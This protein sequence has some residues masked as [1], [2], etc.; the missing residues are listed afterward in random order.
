[1]KIRFLFPLVLACI[2]FVPLATALPPDPRLDTEPM[3]ATGSRGED[4]DVIPGEGA[5]GEWKGALDVGVMQLRL[6]L[7]VTQLDDGAL[8]GTL[9]SLDQGAMGIPLDT[10]ESGD[11]VLR[12]HIKSIGAFYRGEINEDGSAI[13]GTWTQLGREHPLTFNRTKTAFTLKR[14]QEP[15]PPFPYTSEEVR[16]RN[17]ADA[18]TLAGTLLVPEGEGPF[19]AVLM[20]TGSGPQDRDE[21]L[22]GHKPFLVIADYLARRGIAS[23]RY[24][25]RGFGESG[26]N[27]M[28]ST[29]TDFAEDASAGIAY[30]KS[31]PEIR[32]S[33]IGI[34]GHSE[35]GL[36]GAMVAS[37]RDDVAFLVLLAAPGESFAKLL[38]RQTRDILRLKGVEEDLINRHVAH[39]ESAIA[40]IRD[41]SLPRAE[42]KEK[43]GKLAKDERASYTEEEAKAL[44][45][46][47]AAIERN[48]TISTTP[49]FRSLAR[50][51]PADYLGEID[52]P[53]LALFGGKDVQVAAEVNAAVMRSLLEQADN[54]DFEV[55]IL[56]G[57]NHLF[58]HA[59]TGA[60]REY[61]K[62]EETFAPEALERMGDWIAERFVR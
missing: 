14:P 44:G 54:P 3:N 16:F 48:I 17:E 55:A 30:L 39:L 40:L 58:Q 62:I 19:P 9:D 5:V 42:L 45:F 33:A 2:A 22:M 38:V 21:L 28:A 43:L 51:D 41:A 53:T 8:A 57:L 11:G 26:G 56:P 60:I 34:V 24:D 32:Q 61:G 23:L 27:H 7:H 46:D 6:A 4:R 36:T 52:I 12:F 59:D 35:G 20:I 49:W 31:R 10:I 1:M 47:K 13:E 37:E 15:E 18:V 50:E 29:V 25:D